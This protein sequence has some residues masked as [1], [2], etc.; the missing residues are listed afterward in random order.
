MKERALILFRPLAGRVAYQN[1]T[2]QTN[3]TTVPNPI[4]T[5]YRDFDYRDGNLG[6]AR[7]PFGLRLK[8]H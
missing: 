2:G 6:L 3:P 5:S 4:F 7:L 8:P 1:R